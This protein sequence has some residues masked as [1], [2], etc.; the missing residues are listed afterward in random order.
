MAG[1]CLDELLA[2]HQES[3]SDM[4]SCRLASGEPLDLHHWDY[5][6]WAVVVMEVNN[7]FF[8]S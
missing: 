1:V 3:P 2:H 5:A 8:A 7:F 4:A 6:S